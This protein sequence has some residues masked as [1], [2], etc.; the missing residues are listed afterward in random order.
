MVSLPRGL[1]WSCIANGT[2]L[3]SIR[4]LAELTTSYLSYPLWPGGAGNFGSSIGDGVAYC[5]ILGHLG[6]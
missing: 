5:Y 1:N 3:L 2:I 6:L 4:V